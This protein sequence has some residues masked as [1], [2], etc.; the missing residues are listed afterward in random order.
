MVAGRQQREERRRLRRDAAGERD[1]A[2]TAFEVG[3]ALLEHGDGRVHD[4]RVGVAVLLQVEIRGR[5]F[6]IL[7]HVARGLKDRHGARAG[8]RIGPLPGV[9]LT[10]FESKVT[11]LFHVLPEL[12]PGP[13]SVACGGPI[14]PRRSLAGAPCAPRASFLPS[15]KLLNH[16]SLLLPGSAPTRLG[17]LR[18]P[19]Y[20]APLPRRRAVRA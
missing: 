12:C 11:G 20:P 8:I 6:R 1:R 15:K 2:A 5:R 17:R 7:E 9:H 14:A 19:H 3:H 16:G 13:G 10:R 4:P 18:R